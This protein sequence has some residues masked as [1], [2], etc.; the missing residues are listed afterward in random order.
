MATILSALSPNVEKDDFCL[1]LKVFLRPWQWRRGRDIHQLE[2]DFASYLGVKYAFAFNSGRSALMAILWSLKLKSES[3]VLVSGFT[4]NA[5]VN[6]IRWNKLTPQFVDITTNLNISFEDLEKKID[7][8]S[9]VILVQHTFGLPVDMKKTQAIAQKNNLTIVEDV[10]HALGGEF[11]EKKLG[12]FGQAAFFSLGRDKVVSSSS[13]GLA[14]TNNKEL[15]KKLKIFQG[16]CTHPSY[17]WTAQQL[18]HPIL[19]YGLVIPA[20]QKGKIGR[21]ILIGLQK[22]RILDKAVSKQEKRGEKPKYLPGQMPN[23]LAILARHQLLKLAKYNQHRQQ[24]AQIYNQ[25]ISEEGMMRPI[26][27]EGRI[28]L[29]YPIILKNKTSASVLAKFRQEKILLYDGWQDSPIVPPDTCL[30]T[31]GYVLGDCSEAESISRR[32]INLPTHIHISPKEARR[33]ASWAKEFISEE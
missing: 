20:Y 13:G 2:K 14:V 15:A 22:M 3:G 28:Y 24:I 9:Q 7:H 6:P 5:A 30:K 27:I 10:A 33:I 12:T 32:L 1:S 8:H 18:L 11:E 21:W 19:T 4:C 31:V 23:A 29:K 26:S 17:F 16:K 25:E